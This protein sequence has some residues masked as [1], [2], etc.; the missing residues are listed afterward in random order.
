MAHYNSFEDLPIWQ[1]ARLL[2]KR[3]YELTQMAE[4]A[5]DHGLK[6]QIQRASVSIMSNIAE[7]FERETDKDKA[8]FLGYA[9]ASVGEV[10]SQ[11]FLALDLGYVSEEV[12]Q[13]MN[14]RFKALASQI[15]GFK[16]YLKG[17]DK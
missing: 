8:L 7:G 6:N 13:P 14:D 4:F 16:N 10:R 12:H 9:K 5:K 2:T 3:I 17:R 11:L 15:A 1:E